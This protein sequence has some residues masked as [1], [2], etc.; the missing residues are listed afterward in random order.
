MVALIIAF[1]I[2][3]MPSAA[4]AASFVAKDVALRCSPKKNF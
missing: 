2:Q 1:S 4:L 3:L